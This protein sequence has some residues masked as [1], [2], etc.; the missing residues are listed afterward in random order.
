MN[1]PLSPSAPLNRIPPDI[2]RARDYETAARRFIAAPDYEYIAGGSSD[3]ATL[4]V[5][6]AAFTRWSIWP[7]VLRDV[8]AGHTRVSFAGLEFPH[9]IFLAPVAHQLLV[10]PAGEMETARGAA[11]VDSCMIASTLSSRSLEEIATV[12]TAHRW[13]QLYFQPSRVHTLDL[14]RRAESAGF[15]A[16]V[17]TVDASIQAPSARALHAGFRMPARCKATNLERYEGTSL[18]TANEHGGRILQGLMRQAPTW[19]DLDWLLAE[20]RLPVWIKGVMH[21]EDARALRDRDVAGVVISN[22]GGRTLDGVPASL[23]ALPSAR[24]AVGD[25]FPLLF[26]GGIRSG[27]D[28]FKAIALGANAVLIGRLQLYALS[29]AGALGVA[30]MIRLL[31]EELEACMAVAGCATLSDIRR[32]HLL[33]PG[34]EPP[35]C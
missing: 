24:A 4:A 31:R 9:P 12:P 2:H 5:N 8:T 17:V 35:A 1:D 33:H 7:R 30:H 26:D 14:V 22:H 15:T 20:T 16:L 34:S 28:V 11:A 23:S 3:D 25:D 18:A 19:P 6:A 21:S 10:H 29:V 13:F 32:A 27:A